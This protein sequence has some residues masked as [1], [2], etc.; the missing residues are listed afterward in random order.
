MHSSPLRNA[1]RITPRMNPGTPW[2]V[3]TL[4]W[5][6]F[7]RLMSSRLWRASTNC[8]VVIVASCVLLPRCLRGGGLLLPSVSES[9]GSGL[10]GGVPS[11]LC[12]R[13]GRCLSLP[14]LS[15]ACCWGWVS[16]SFP[17]PRPL[18]RRLPHGLLL[19]LCFGVFWLV[20]LMHCWSSASALD[21]HCYLCLY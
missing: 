3:S 12:W 8:G 18:P 6:T 4:C 9:K 10:G 7:R 13:P 2:S 21:A 5:K 17:L 14:C 19:V 15:A 16:R 11:V 20:A 1:V